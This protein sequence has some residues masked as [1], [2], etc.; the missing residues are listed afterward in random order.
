MFI[1]DSKDGEVY[2]ICSKVMYNTDGIKLASDWMKEP[3][4]GVK[5]HKKSFSCF[6]WY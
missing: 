3:M 6:K 1:V 4:K 5:T 2:P